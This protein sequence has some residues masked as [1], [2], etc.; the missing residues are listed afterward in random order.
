[1]YNFI[2]KSEIRSTFAL[3]LFKAMR[4]NEDYR[5]KFYL[6]SVYTYIFHD[7]W[8]EAIRSICLRHYPLIRI[9]VTYATRVKLHTT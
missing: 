6:T 3:F 9:E 5:C 2:L 1:M 4:R 8:I 7:D